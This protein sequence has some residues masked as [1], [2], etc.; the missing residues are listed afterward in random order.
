MLPGKGALK[1]LQP[2]F[3]AISTQAQQLKQDQ[4]VVPVA[5]ADFN[6]GGNNQ[7]EQAWFAAPIIQQGYLHSYV[8]FQLDINKIATLLPDKPQNGQT[9]QTL[10]VGQDHHMRLPNSGDLPQQLISPAINQ[11]LAG[12]TGVGSLLNYN[13]IAVLSAFTP[14]KIFNHTW[15]LVVELPE[16]KHLLVFINSKKSFCSHAYCHRISDFSR[17]LVIKLNNGSPI[18]LNLGI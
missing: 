5:F 11:A 10:L 1:G 7:S 18:T 4:E 16:K 12:K 9:V 6:L 17:S 8:F 15:A 3:Q 13:N 2:T 14:I